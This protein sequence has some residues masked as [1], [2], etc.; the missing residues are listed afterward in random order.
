MHMDT[1]L[2]R[3]QTLMQNTVD[4]ELYTSLA[5]LAKG[6]LLVL[7]ITAGDDSIYSFCF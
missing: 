7:G 1:I 2:A 6:F 5:V 4:I 3:A